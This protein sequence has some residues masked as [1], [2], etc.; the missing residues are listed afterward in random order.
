MPSKSGQARRAY[1]SLID[2]RLVGGFMLPVGH[3]AFDGYKFIAMQVPG[4]RRWRT[5]SRVPQKEE[6]A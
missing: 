6:E 2:F 4:A 5:V 1:D 3:K